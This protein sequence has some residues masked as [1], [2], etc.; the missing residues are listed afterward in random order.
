M[1]DSSINIDT[2]AG[3][4]RFDFNIGN[5]EVI[6]FTRDPKSQHII[7]IDVKYLRSKDSQ[8]TD[9]TRPRSVKLCY[10]TS[11]PQINLQQKGD[12]VTTQ[13]YNDREGI[14]ATIGL[15][16]HLQSLFP[17]GFNLNVNISSNKYT[18][19]VRDTYL[20]PPAEGVSGIKSISAL[21]ES[22]QFGNMH[23][24]GDI[25]KQ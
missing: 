14:K 15:F 25:V 1:G 13:E 7:N 19:N 16:N 24:T 18:D 11:Q 12:S 23:L 5:G 17:Q 10:D 9:S 6:S 22:P 4:L 21:F 2:L 8:P 20:I 3:N